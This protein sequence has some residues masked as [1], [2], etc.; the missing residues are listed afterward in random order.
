[1]SFDF[2]EK[3]GN[4]DSGQRTYFYELFAH[5]LTDSMRGILF[6]EG[7]SDKDRIERAKWLN[8]I[9]HRITYKIFALQKTSTDFSEEEIWEMINKN[10]AR[11]PKTEDDVNY[12]IDLSY[13]YVLENE[14]ET[15]QEANAA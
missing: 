12:A 14:S 10:V 6:Q 15:A 5:F 1:M 2:S 9:Q 13:G 4:L 11:H 8:E 7:I 3:I